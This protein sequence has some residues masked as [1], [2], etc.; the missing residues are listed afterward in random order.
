MENVFKKLQKARSMLQSMSLKKSGHNKFAG[1]HYF[2]LGDFLTP[3]NSIFDQVGLCGVTSFTKEV[4]T[5]Q[6]FN[7]DKIDEVITFTSPMGSA[8]LKGCH[9]VQ[10]IGAV[11]TYQRRYLWVVALEI[12]EHDAIDSVEPIKEEKKYVKPVA[13]ESFDSLTSEDQDYLRS[14]AIEI[15]SS[16]SKNDFASAVDYLDS[17]ALDA[18][19]KVALWALLD[20]KQRAGIKAETEQRKQNKK[21][22]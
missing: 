1:Y 9:E 17:L 2:E 4:A 20:S 21:E 5:L 19:S 10:N 15:I 8:A 11:E 7:S 14:C 16:A 18:N 6:V 13:K 22:V 12:V 3:I